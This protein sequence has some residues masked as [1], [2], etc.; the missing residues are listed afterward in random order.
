MM[1]TFLNKYDEKKNKQ[2][3]KQTKQKKKQNL[4]LANTLITFSDSKIY[5]CYVSKSL[6]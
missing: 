1:A 2:T 3:N 5:Y 6:N 4:Q